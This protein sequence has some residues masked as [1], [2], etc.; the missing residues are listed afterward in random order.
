M[1][2]CVVNYDIIVNAVIRVVLMH[3]HTMLYDFCVVIYYSTYRAQH[4]CCL[5]LTVA[6][7]ATVH[8]I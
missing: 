4:T 5:E 1:Y 8:N 3:V 6:S 7:L 2:D